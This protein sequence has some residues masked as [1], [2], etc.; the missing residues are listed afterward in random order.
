MQVFNDVLGSNFKKSG[1]YNLKK[2]INEI[3]QNGFTKDEIKATIEYC[4]SEVK[5]PNSSFDKS[6]MTPNFIFTF[7]VFCDKF[8]HSKIKISDSYETR[9]SKFL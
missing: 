5:D 7:G 2:K 6:K 3:Y 4:W 8:E 9:K 1:D